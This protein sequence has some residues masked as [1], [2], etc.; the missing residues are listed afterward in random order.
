MELPAPNS[1]TR[2][3]GEESSLRLGKPA[4]GE[5]SASNSVTRARGDELSIRSGK[6]QKS[7][8]GLSDRTVCP[9]FFIHTVF[10]LADRFAIGELLPGAI[11]D[12]A[13]EYYCRK[14]KG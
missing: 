8:E 5:S 10:D 2:A 13:T 12:R 9:G 11:F 7:S 1:V 3:R 6:R 14:A 4:S